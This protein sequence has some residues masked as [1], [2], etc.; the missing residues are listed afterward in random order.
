METLLSMRAKSHNELARDFKALLAERIS[1][2]MSGDAA[3]IPRVACDA[4][5]YVACPTVAGSTES[6]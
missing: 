6:S 5:A 2:S 1:P 4:A 3:S